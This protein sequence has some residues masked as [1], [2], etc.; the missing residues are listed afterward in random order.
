M[1]GELTSAVGH[2]LGWSE[3]EAAVADNDS[4]PATSPAAQTNG[5]QH[6]DA[7]KIHGELSPSD[8]ATSSTMEA[9]LE[10][11]ALQVPAAV[12]ESRSEQDEPSA[13]RPVTPTRNNST[14][15]S[16]IPLPTPPHTREGSL[17]FHNALSPSSAH[18][19]TPSRASI[20]PRPSGHHRRTSSASMSSA[21]TDQ[22][23]ASWANSFSDD[24]LQF[25]HAAGFAPSSSDLARPGPVSRLSSNASATSGAPTLTSSTSFMGED[26]FSSGVSSAIHDAAR[27]TDWDTVKHLCEENPDAAKFV[28]KDRWTA[29]HHACSRRCPREDVVEALI[30]A[31]PDALLLEVE[32]GWYPLHFACRFKAPLEVIRLLVHMHPGMGLLTVQKLDR[33]GRTPLYY[34]VRYDAPAGVVGTLLDVD[35]SVVLE[36]DQNA[37]SPIGL[38]WDQWAE[39]LEGKRTLQRIH[40]S[41]STNESTQD[42]AIRVAKRLQSQT[43]VLERWNNVNIFLKAAFGFPVGDKS[44]KT[45]DVDE[46]NR[47]GAFLSE[48]KAPDGRTWRIL[49]AAAAIKCHISLFQLACTLHPDQA[50]EFDE[51]DLRGPSNFSGGWNS[52]KHMTALH[53]AASS[54]ANGEGGRHVLE[55]LLLMHPQA[56]EA[57]DGKGA[58]P[59]HRLAGNR[60]KSHWI[61]DGV[62]AIYEAYTNAIRAV[63]SEGRLPLHRAATAIIPQ[64]E[65]TDETVTNRSVLC[66]LLDL[67]PDASAHSD[68]FGRLPLHLA[69]QNSSSWDIQLQNLLDQFP[70]AVRSRTGVKLGNLLPLHMAASNPAAELSL[71]QKLVD[72]HPRAASQASREGKLPLHYACETGLSWNAVSVILEAHSNAIRLPEQNSNGLNALQMAASCKRSD[73]ELLVNLLALH[74][75][76]ASISN[77]KGRYALHLA[78]IAGK[79]WDDG[80]SDLFDAFPD[81]VSIAD[82]FGLLPFYIVCFRYCKPMT[83]HNGDLFDCSTRYED[84]KQHRRC[85]TSSTTTELLPKEQANEEE[86]ARQVGILFE[87]LKANPTVL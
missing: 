14:R 87:L 41:A 13:Q 32:K 82:A 5:Q 8:D 39:K 1:F 6:D 80:L 2:L 34:A 10:V 44:S 59:L 86:E 30:R 38:I 45:T 74:P 49:H 69:A 65:A 83:G 35:P 12:A 43:K 17:S 72:S 62:E 64:G 52:A 56:V 20:S 47:V 51:N 75:E 31:Y 24:P 42:R 79:S 60:A 46:G 28:G 71:I 61:Q 37:D 7:Q 70:Q 85:S 77:N 78:C 53:L 58:L 66:R 40:G 68:S 67:H 25:L 18:A 36:E 16:S 63:D 81:S 76:S 3:P 55:T 4:S 26:S 9:D 15:Q 84:R 11:A 19:R 73:K 21:M 50:L 57:K 27:I 33:Q 23:H 54:Q 22:M 29:L 48:T